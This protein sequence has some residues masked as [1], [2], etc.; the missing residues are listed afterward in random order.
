MAKSEAARAKRMNRPIF[1]SSFFS[2]YWSGSKFLTSPAK[3]QGCCEA[4]KRVMGAMPLWPAQSAFQT[5]SVPMPTP[6]SRPTPVTTTRRLLTAHL[7]CGRETR[8][9][10][11]D[12]HGEGY[13]FF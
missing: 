5:S 8:T 9:A 7:D 12:P 13:D 4:S 1:F 10:Q 11:E 2:T 6:Q 3:R